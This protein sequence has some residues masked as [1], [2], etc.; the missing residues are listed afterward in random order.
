[1]SGERGFSLV[2]L[3]VASMLGTL[4]AGG[5]LSFY[6]ATTRTVV[7]SNAQ[8]ALQRQGSLAVEEIS[9][10]VRSAVDPGDTGGLPA[11]SLTTCN[12]VP[13]S[14]QVST[15]SD[16]SV[17][18]YADRGGA[19]CEYRDAKAGCRNL[20]AGGL[21]RIVLLTQT[22]P[23]DPRCPPTVAPGAPCFAMTPNAAASP[24][25]VD[26]AFAIRDSDGDLDGMN[27]MT[28]ST[29]LTCSGRNC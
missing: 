29:S 26:V 20:L 23:A 28:F 5:L 18:Y 27:A 16:G 15:P 3:L 8:A 2:E 13:G 12:G 22:S 19:L 21:K 9:R 11:I 14:V 17:C 7:E 4:V 1:M 6:V 24:T 10:Q 25:R